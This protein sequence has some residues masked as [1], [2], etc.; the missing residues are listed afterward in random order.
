MPLLSIEG[1]LCYFFYYVFHVFH[2][3]CCKVAV[4]IYGSTFI[5]LAHFLV[6]NRITPLK[7]LGLPS[8]RMLCGYDVLCEESSWEVPT[9][10]FVKIF[11]K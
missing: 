5:F 2:S 6:T 4:E 9:V 1:L 7:R 10:S 3:G 11:L 8:S